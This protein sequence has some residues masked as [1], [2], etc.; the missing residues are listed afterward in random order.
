MKLKVCGLTNKK[1]I[2]D[3][4]E[5]AYPDYLGFLF[6]TNSSRYVIGRLE[7]DDVLNIPESIKKTGIFVNSPSNW[8]MKHAREYDLSTLQL[9]GEESPAYCEKLKSEGYE[10]IKVFKI[11]DE[12]DFLRMSSYLPV[13]DSFLFDTAGKFRGG[14]G[15]KF[16]WD[17]LKNYNHNIPYFLSGGIKPGDAV[18]INSI[19]D[20]RLAGVDI[21]SGFEI[22]PGIKD[23]VKVQSFKDQLNNK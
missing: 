20:S 6:Y 18:S 23:P 21:N 22:Q 1:N 16:D 17:I 14:N 5:K 12:M 19:K 2:Q 4:I 15:I 8:V 7:P 3:I 9:H 10:I 11:K 13:V